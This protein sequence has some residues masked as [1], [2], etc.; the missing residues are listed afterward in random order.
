MPV[1]VRRKTSGKYSVS[2]GGKV[3]A[4]GTTR[5]KAERQARLLRALD[6]GW[7]PGRA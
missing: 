3:S 2:H 1:K 5:R 7:R 4:K 6:H